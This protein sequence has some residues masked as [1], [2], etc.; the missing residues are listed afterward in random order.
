MWDEQFH[1]LWHRVFENLTVS[2]IYEFIAV[3]TEPGT[4]WD[5]EAIRQLRRQIKEEI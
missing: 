5:Y 2:E 4:E 1:D 3:I